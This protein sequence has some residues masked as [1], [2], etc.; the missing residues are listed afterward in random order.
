M[1]TRELTSPAEPAPITTMIALEAPRAA[2]SAIHPAGAERIDDLLRDEG[3]DAEQQEREPQGRREDPRQALDLPELRPRVHVHEGPGQHSGL[4]DE[5]EH[6]HPHGREAHREVDDEEREH[7]YQAQ[8][9]EVERAVLANPAVD[10]L[11]RPLEAAADRGAGEVAGEEEGERRAEGGGEGD[12]DGPPA[13][14]EDR[15]RDEGEDRG[16]G[17]GEPGDRDV[18]REERRPYA[19]RVGDEEVVQPAALRLE[20]GEV[21]IAAE[22]EREERGDEHHDRGEDA[23][24][25]P[26][27]GSGG[28]PGDGS[29]RHARLHVRSDPC[30]PVRRAPRAGSRK[31]RRQMRSARA[32]GSRRGVQGHVRVSSRISEEVS[33]RPPPIAC[34]SA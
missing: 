12:N 25:S 18:D 26:V 34:T 10:P 2:V 14:P 30:R 3:E 15:P 27:H 16:A 7:G 20:I 33:Q 29:R 22:V 4:A 8:G 31:K 1:P 17:Q 24:L 5:R 32:G 19:P 21:E 13:E 23:E 28:S 9:E 6:E 11:Q